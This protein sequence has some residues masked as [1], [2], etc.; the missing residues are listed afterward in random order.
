MA[1]KKIFRYPKTVF[2]V[3][4]TDICSPEEGG[5][6]LWATPFGTCLIRGKTVAGFQR[7]EQL[8]KRDVGLG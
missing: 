3:P 7:K 4:P 6:A 2:P 5:R 8:V 1:T